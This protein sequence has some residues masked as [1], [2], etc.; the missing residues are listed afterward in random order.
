MYSEATSMLAHRI[1]AIVIAI[2]SVSYFALNRQTEVDTEAM[3]D[4]SVSVRAISHVSVDRYGDSVWEPSSGS[5][6]LV[7]SQ[8]CEVWT[9]H[10]VV[11]DAAVIEVFPR[12]WPKAHGIPAKLVNSTP[13][14]DVAILKMENCDGMQAAKLGDSN[15]VKTGDETFV[16]G[17]PFGRN[18]D[19]VS[20]GII[21]HTERFLSAPAAYFQT[22][23]AVNPGNSGGALFNEDGIVIGLTTAIANNKSKS[24]VGIGYAMPINEVTDVVGKLR[25]GPASWGDAGLKGLLASLTAEEAAIFNITSGDPAV[26]VMR[27]PISGPAKD[28]IFARDVIYAVNDQSITNPSHIHR[29]IGSRNPGEK[30]SFA[31]VREGEFIEVELELEDGGKKIASIEKKADHYSGLLGM[32]VEM[33]T[34]HNSMRGSYT[35]P[36][37]TRIHSMGPA[38][39]GFIVSSQS[40]MAMR[41]QIVLPVQLSVRTVTGAVLEGH[42]KPINDIGTL[43]DLAKEAYESNNALLLEIESWG[44]QNSDWSVPLQKSASAFYRI[45]PKPSTNVSHQDSLDDDYAIPSS[46]QSERERTNTIDVTRKGQPLAAYAGIAA[47]RE[48]TPSR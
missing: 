14:M 25:E 44:R 12:G 2:A 41:G 36:V 38:H 43:N 30:V 5:G 40:S 24:N 13:Q 27:S 11:D 34:E 39:R 32:Q 23:A 16:V 7:S 45:K 15:L 21:S 48:S 31:I 10:H 35:S 1:F 28:Q 37:I 22:D 26:S 6:F 19:S 29:I 18:P 4:V 9:N 42:Y 33:W 17:N 46:V 20:R 3:R 47:H 8:S